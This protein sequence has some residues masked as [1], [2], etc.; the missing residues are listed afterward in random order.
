MVLIYYRE[1]SN[2]VYLDPKS[3]CASQTRGR[4]EWKLHKEVKSERC[5]PSFLNG[6]LERDGLILWANMPT[7]F[8]Q[9][10]FVMKLI[11]IGASLRRNEIWKFT[12]TKTV[13][14]LGDIENRA[15]TTQKQRKRKASNSTGLPR[16]LGGIETKLRGNQT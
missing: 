5:Q 13:S 4:K 9:H 15:R 3:K 7:G 10:R 16:D 11:L 14:I 8:F 12:R 6:I 1:A 2:D